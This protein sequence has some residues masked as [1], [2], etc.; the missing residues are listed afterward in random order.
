MAN[1]EEQ[2]PFNIPKPDLSGLMQRVIATE[3]AIEATGAYEE[4][5]KTHKFDWRK[6]VADVEAHPGTLS[7]WDMSISFDEF[8]RRVKAG[9]F[10]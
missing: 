7:S 1:H 5:V 8:A 4:S 9:E 3:A 6:F 10:D 2:Y